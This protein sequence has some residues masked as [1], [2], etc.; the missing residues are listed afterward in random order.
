MTTIETKGY[1]MAI[2]LCTALIGFSLYF[3]WDSDGYYLRQALLVF[4]GYAT[5]A[6]IVLIKEIGE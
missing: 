5:G 6:L 4:A 2:A 3:G 1:G